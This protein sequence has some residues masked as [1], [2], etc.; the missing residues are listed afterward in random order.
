MFTNITS[1]FCA[2]NELNISNTVAVIVAIDFRQIILNV[3]G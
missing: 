1:L 3:F 2:L